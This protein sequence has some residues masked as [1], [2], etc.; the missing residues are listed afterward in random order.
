LEYLSVRGNKLT[1][2]NELSGCHALWVVDATQNALTSVK[3]LASLPVLG[4]LL[5]EGNDVSLEQLK[6]LKPVHIIHLEVDLT[7]FTRDDVIRALPSKQTA[8][9]VDLKRHL[10][11]G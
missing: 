2:L 10:H 7:S 3:A 5:L 4:T 9:T 8:R 11:H 1:T 6:D